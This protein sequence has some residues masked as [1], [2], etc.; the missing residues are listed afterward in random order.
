[1]TDRPKHHL[2]TRRQSLAVIGVA[3]AGGLLANGRML[4]RWAGLD[5]ASAATA[6]A[7]CVLTPEQEEGPFYVDLERARRNIARGKDGVPLLLRVRVINAESC[8]PIQNAAVDVW[9][10]DAL[11][12]YLKPPRALR[13]RAT[14]AASSSPMRTATPSSGRSIPAFTRDVPLTYT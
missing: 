13:A 11:G 10:C 6:A 12:R 5:E 9:H 1:M 14:C 3:G 2:L 8:R 7:S 4:S